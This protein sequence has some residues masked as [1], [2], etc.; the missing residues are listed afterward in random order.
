MNFMKET[1]ESVSQTTV[2]IMNQ[3]V[4]FINHHVA[5]IELNPLYRKTRLSQL[6]HPKASGFNIEDIISMTM[7]Q[8][9]RRVQIDIVP[10]YS[11]TP[12]GVEVKV[13]AHAHKAAQFPRTM[14]E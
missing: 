3:L 10:S 5:L 7:S 1:L 2:P 8:K 11:F 9:P 6:A 12:S 14:Y 13:T 4:F